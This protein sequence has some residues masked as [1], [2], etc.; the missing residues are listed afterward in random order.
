MEEGEKES[1]QVS[2]FLS[3]AEP[4]LAAQARCCEARGSVRQLLVDGRYF[5]A[6]WKRIEALQDTVGVTLCAVAARP[7]C[8]RRASTEPTFTGTRAPLSLSRVILAKAVE[9]AT[10]VTSNMGVCVKGNKLRM[11]KEG[12]ERSAE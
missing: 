4:R 12:T 3:S 8:L 7:L 6:R 1:K 5:A 9:R 2:S 11:R 10:R